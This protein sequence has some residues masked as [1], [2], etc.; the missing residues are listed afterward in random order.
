MGKNSGPAI[1]ARENSIC[2]IYLSEWS[3]YVLLLRSSQT[4]DHPFGSGEE[5]RPIGVPAA[6]VCRKGPSAFVANKE[7]PRQRKKIMENIPGWEVG[8]W[9][10]EKVFKTLGE[11]EWVDQTLT[12][13][14][15]NSPSINRAL[16]KLE[17]QN[18]QRCVD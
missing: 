6:V 13:F 4:E 3:G 14:Y 17:R 7:K 9:R 11:E 10:G 16:R 8:K 15:G 1:D 2:W 5:Q 18:P 12:E